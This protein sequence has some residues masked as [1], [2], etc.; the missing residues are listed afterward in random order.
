MTSICAVILAPLASACGAGEAGRAPLKLKLPKPRFAGTPKNVKTPNLE[1]PRKAARR[2]PFLAPRGV[3]NVARGK[4]VTSSDGEPIIGE[5]SQITDGNKEAEEG[6]FVEISPGRQWVQI[7]LGRRYGIYAIVMWHFH[8]EARVYRDVVVQV[9]DDPTFRKGVRTVF[10]SDH[11]NSLGLGVGRQKEYFETYE[12]RLID[13]K[14]VVGRH[15][16]LYSNGSTAGD[17]SHCIEVEVYGRVERR[18]AGPA[19]R[20]RRSSGATTRTGR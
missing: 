12:G 18:G 20:P 7:D 3:T 19:T 9:G 14:G 10:N 17:M 4:T 15:V 13:A 5:L 11:D 2:P 16:R 6:S 1:A 8:R